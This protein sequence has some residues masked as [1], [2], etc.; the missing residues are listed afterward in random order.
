MQSVLQN[1]LAR[2]IRRIAAFSQG[3]VGVA[4][5]HMTSGEEILVGD[6][7]LYPLASSVKMA[8]ALAVLDKVERGELAL[9]QHIAVLPFEMNPHGPGGLGDQFFYP[10]VSLSLVNHL[11]GM[12][13]RS[14]NTSTDVLFRVAGGAGAVAD[15]LKRFGIADFECSR[16]MREALCVLHELPLPPDNVSVVEMLKNQPFEVLDAR[17]RTNAQFHHEQRDHARPSAMLRLLEKLWKRDGVS[18]ASAA[19]LIEIMG[20]T[21]TAHD[22]VLARL[23]E[24]IAF[25]SKGGSGAG[26]AVDVGFITLPEGRGT[27]ALAIFVKA[28]PR[29]MD[30]RN[31]V[32]ADIAR[33]VVDAFILALP[34]GWHNSCPEVRVMQSVA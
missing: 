29:D 34:M 2:E 17:N 19:L 8:L 7:R 11:E 28:S 23:P 16:T 9:D 27:L 24:G 32:I 30:S 21:V 22:R 3:E 12:I 10:G 13:T 33:L 1:N 26:A 15:Y 5:R 14:C 6:E 25:A 18:E 31:R 4:A 20:R